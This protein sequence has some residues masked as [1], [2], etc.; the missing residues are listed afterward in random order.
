MMWF[1]PEFLTAWGGNKP[2]MQDIFDIS[3]E[4]YREP[5][6]VNRRTLRFELGGQGFFLKLHWG[7][8]WREIIKN[9]ASMRLPVLGAG[10]EWKAIRRLE[11]VGVETMRLVAYGHAGINPAR[12]RSFVITEELVDCVS[13]EDYCDYWQETPPT[14]VVKTNLV[15]RVAEMARKLHQNGINHRDFY[16]C[17]F[18]LHSPWDTR[19]ESLHLHLIDLHRVQLRKTTPR[20]WVVKDIGALWFSAM[21]IGLTKRDL[22]RFM[23]IYRGVSLRQTLSQDESFWR[24]VEARAQ[25]LDA[26]R[27]PSKPKEATA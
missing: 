24:E 23:Q 17:H 20:R 19:K 21:Q 14:F 12:Q 6:G 10:N 1:S 25:A 7:V 13:L 3:G 4:V 26:T 16:I 2:S 5:S 18:L 8:G 15:R 11:Q 27:P 22:L 9:L